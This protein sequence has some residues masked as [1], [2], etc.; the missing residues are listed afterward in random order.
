ML[1]G[2]AGLTLAYWL[3]FAISFTGGCSERME[4][5]TTKDISGRFFSKDIGCTIYFQWSQPISSELV[6][7][8]VYEFD[9][10]YCIRPNGEVEK[11][12]SPQVAPIMMNF[13]LAG[14]NMPL[15]ISRLRS[16]KSKSDE[17][18]IMRLKRDG[19]IGSEKKS[20][21]YYWIA[22]ASGDGKKVLARNHKLSDAD[23][24]LLEIRI[25]DTS[26]FESINSVTVEGPLWFMQ[27]GGGNSDL[28]KFLFF[29][30]EVKDGADG[31]KTEHVQPYVFTVGEGGSL[32]SEPLEFPGAPSIGLYDAVMIY[33]DSRI[34]GLVPY[35]GSYKIYQT[36]PPYNDFESILELDVKHPLIRAVDRDGSR[37]I[38]TWNTD[39][40]FSS[41]NIWDMETGDMQVFHIENVKE[42]K[43]YGS[44][45]PD[46]E[47]VVLVLYKDVPG[48]DNRT[49]Y[50]SIFNT[51]DGTL[52]E[53]VEWMHGGF[54]DSDIKVGY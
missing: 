5:V 49:Q 1:M 16:D 50:I 21:V 17:S 14:Y 40:G 24:L 3:I 36:Y 8:F 19:S 54:M 13:E 2:K 7:K 43:C 20:D 52:I 9:D 32:K 31:N 10:L 25:I 47:R 12:Y 35:E 30:Q 51:S 45:S 53:T 38:M 37:F 23:E 48:R 39:D 42:E 41:W 28:S 6:S 4:G 27:F 11:V 33:D 44:I 34:V 18:N 22:A 46:G 15:I 29:H 26:T